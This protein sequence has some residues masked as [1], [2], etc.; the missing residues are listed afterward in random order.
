MEG[1]NYVQILPEL[2]II[3]LYCEHYVLS[4][5]ICCKGFSVKLHY[6][7]P[8]RDVS[9]NGTAKWS[10]IKLILPYKSVKSLFWIAHCH[11]V[12][13]NCLR[14][15]KKESYPLIWLYSNVKKSN[16]EI[17]TYISSL[18]CHI[19]WFLWLTYVWTVTA[20]TITNWSALFLYQFQEFILPLRL[21]FTTYFITEFVLYNFWK[22]LYVSRFLESSILTV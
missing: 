5:N 14:I 21:K 2:N 6:V 18:D 17:C 3:G 22:F 7:T 11:S 9:L 12:F 16:E 10:F 15:I 4:R 19:Y 1:N 13:E 20:T 8:L